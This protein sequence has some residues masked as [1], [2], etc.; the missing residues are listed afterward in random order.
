MKHKL[1]HLR[2]ENTDPKIFREL[3]HEISVIL[4]VEATRDLPLENIKVQTPI[5]EADA[6]IIPMEN[7]VIVPILRAGLGMVDGLLSLFPKAKVGHVGMERDHKTHLPTDYYFKLPP[8]LENS[9]YFV[10]DPMLATGGSVISAIQKLK[11][12][13]IKNIR[14]ICVISAPEGGKALQNSHPDV[15][16]FTGGMDD[17]LNKNKYIVPGLGDAG[18]RLFGTN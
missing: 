6:Q 9:I 18:D 2:N 4:G 3:V 12:V 11:D 1:A 10:V 15:S 14:F 5:T 13:G 17:K 8:T 7:I 16:I